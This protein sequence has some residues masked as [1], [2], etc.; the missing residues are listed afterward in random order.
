MNKLKLN[1]ALILALAGANFAKAQT[2]GVFNGATQPTFW[3]YDLSVATGSL[4]ATSIDKIAI[5]N[6]KSVDFLPAPTSATSRLYLPAGTGSK[7][8]V[9]GG[10]L[11]LTATSS[12][13][14]L[15]FSTYD[16]ADAKTV[17]SIFFD[18]SFNGTRAK[19]GIIILGF[20]Q[21]MPGQVFNN[22]NQ[23][24]STAAST[25]LFGG[26][27]LEFYGGD[28]IQTYYRT[29]KFANGN[30]EDFKT[31]FDRNAD[32]QSVEIYCNNSAKNQSYKRDN[33]KFKLPAKTFH[34]FV[35]GKQLVADGS[36][37]IPATGEL[38]VD[39]V[40]NSIIFNTSSST[41]NLL[42]F[43]ISNLKVGGL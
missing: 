19:N 8:D 17:S 37:D 28:D 12:G 4:A 40:I 24:L 23:I 13:S 26:L 15:K 11:K 1:L 29:S 38:A 3:S 36:S 7:A 21:N 33:K 5:S 14:P 27:R 9:S 6:S 42:N 18:I 2:Y 20:G 22:T 39:Q 25:G 30:F 43:S 31:I 32:K 16:I 35:A 34:V 10:A 41:N